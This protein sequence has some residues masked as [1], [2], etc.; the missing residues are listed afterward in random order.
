MTLNVS[1]PFRPLRVRLGIDDVTMVARPARVTFP[2]PLVAA[3]EKVS[4]AVGS[5]ATRLAPVPEPVRAR[6]L[7][8]PR[9]VKLMGSVLVW[10]VPASAVEPGV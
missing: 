7:P 1:T 6:V 9:P 8:A 3:T 5:L 2:F 10:T 4:L